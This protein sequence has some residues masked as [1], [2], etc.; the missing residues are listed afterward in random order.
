[1]NGL[2]SGIKNRR[3]AEV[4]KRKELM[5]KREEIRKKGLM[6]ATQRMSRVNFRKITFKGKATDS[7]G[8]TE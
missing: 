3:D 6:K 1:M 4:S 2:D 7:G 8:K 5:N